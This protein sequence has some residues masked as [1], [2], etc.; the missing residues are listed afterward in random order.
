MK[1]PELM[2]MAESTIANS[3]RVP[4]VDR[5]IVVPSELLSIIDQM[6]LALPEDM[7]EAQRILEEKDYIISQA[8]DE[9]KRIVSEAEDE[10]QAKVRD[11]DMVKLA[12]QRASEIVGE[13]E[14]QGAAIKR[15]ADQYALDILHRL[16]AQ[17]SG[18]L[19]SIQKGIESL[20]E[21]PSKV[22]GGQEG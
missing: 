15:G 16:D 19:T 7:K 18:F 1:L 6:R 13:A 3:L 12:E 14:R 5:K 20:R 8:Q 9:A 10:V 21:E 4:L 2:E 11:I 22:G 17:L